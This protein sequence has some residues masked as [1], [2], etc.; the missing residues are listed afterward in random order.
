MTRSTL[1]LILVLGFS[2]ASGAIEQGDYLFLFAQIVDCGTDSHVVDYA[3][4][5]LNGQATFMNGVT[6]TVTGKGKKKIAEKLAVEIAKKSG[7]KPDSLYVKTV[8]GANVSQ[9]AMMLLQLSLR[10]SCGEDQDAPAEDHDV[11]VER[12]NLR[13]ASTA[14]DKPEPQ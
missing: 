7:H 6:L 1:G 2:P 11:P 3:K 10:H 13:L 5:S 9:V 4:V 14:P 12:Y 8:P